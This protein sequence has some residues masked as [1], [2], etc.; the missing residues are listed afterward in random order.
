MSFFA[1]FRAKKFFNFD[2]KKLTL[3]LIMIW[4]VPFL[5]S[6]LILLLTS[7]AKDKK[8]DGYKY[9]ESGYKNYTRWR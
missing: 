8:E 2:K 1:S 7:K 3:N 5:W 6:M 4:V 9:M